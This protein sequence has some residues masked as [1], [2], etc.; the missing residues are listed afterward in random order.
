MNEKKCPACGKW[1]D[2]KADRCVYCHTA[3]SHR[4]IV[5]E[6]KAAHAEKVREMREQDP[7]KF[8]RYLYKLS[9]SEKPVHQFLFRSLTVVFNVYM[10]ILSFFIW[11]IALISG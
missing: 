8:R 3:I 4:L 5:E 9:K 11:L 1:T 10:A 2:G 6:E 7:S